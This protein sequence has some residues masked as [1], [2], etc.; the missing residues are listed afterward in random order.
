MASAMSF[1]SEYL[2]QNQIHTSPKMTYVLHDY[3]TPLNH[4]TISIELT[5]AR[6]QQCNKC[7]LLINFPS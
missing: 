3:E 5:N 7:S 6:R 1:S 2:I 4:F